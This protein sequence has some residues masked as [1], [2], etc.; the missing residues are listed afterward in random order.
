V[1]GVGFSLKGVAKN[2][3]AMLFRNRPLL[4]FSCIVA[5]GLLSNCDA[6]AATGRPAVGEG[7]LPSRLF[8]DGTV[9]LVSPK[10]P[11]V[12]GEWLFK[13]PQSLRKADFLTF[14]GAFDIDGDGSP[15]VFLDYWH[16]FDNPR[17]ETV[18]LL[19]YKRIRGKYQQYLKL[20]AE[21]IGYAP[22][23]WFIN[24]SPHPKAIFMTRYGGSS[25]TGLFYLNMN[26][27][28]LDLISSPMFLEAYPKFLDLDGD[29]VKEIFL[30]GRGRDRTSNPGGAI[31]RWKDDGY[32]MWW[33]DWT[34][35]PTVIYASVADMDGNGKKEVVAVLEPEDS[36]KFTD[37][38]TWMPRE[39]GV[40]KVATEGITLVSKTKIPDSRYLA[41][42]TIGRVPPFSPIIELEY[43]RTVGCALVGD[44]LSC[45]EEEQR[46]K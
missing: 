7:S 30:H 6:I 13:I 2:T 4:L 25:G 14:Y 41:Y 31:L 1:E 42:P 10:K 43:V 18:V 21:S 20:K 27:K 44:E 40:W 9:C 46:D 37:G 8:P 38:G 12:C 28:S 11:L 23:A 35:L 3:A 45:H 26:K 17:E 33:P 19:V 16:P 29:G 36:E 15:E 32:K 5:I 39:L 34:G 24:E 22:A